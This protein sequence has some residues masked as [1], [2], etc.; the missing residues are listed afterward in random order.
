VIAAINNNAPRFH[1]MV[2]QQRAAYYEKI[3][4]R[5]PRRNRKFASNWRKRYNS[6]PKEIVEAAAKKK[7]FRQQLSPSGLV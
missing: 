6:F 4:A 5:N 2:W 7:T 1:A 3:I